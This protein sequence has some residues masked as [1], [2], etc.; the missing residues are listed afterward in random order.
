MQ[1]NPNG[2]G[3]HLLSTAAVVAAMGLVISSLAPWS[4]AIPATAAGLAATSGQPN[5]SHFDRRA[6]IAETAAARSF[7]CPGAGLWFPLASGNVGWLYG[8]SNPAVELHEGAVVETGVDFTP[9]GSGSKPAFAPATG[10]VTMVNGGGHSISI[11]TRP[12]SR[13][14]LDVYLSGLGSIRVAVGDHVVAGRSIIGSVSAGGTIHMS[15]GPTGAASHNDKLLHDTQDPS[16]LF[17][18]NVASDNKAPN[19]AEHSS[20]GLAQWCHVR[21]SCHGTAIFVNRTVQC[22]AS[23]WGGSPPYRF[24]WRVAG[25]AQ[26]ARG[27][28][29]LTKF[30]QPGAHSVQTVETDKTGV[31]TKA[32]TAVAVQQPSVSFSQI[33]TGSGYSCGLRA[34]GPEA[35]T[36]VCWGGQPWDP[37]TNPEDTGTVMDAPPDI[38]TQ[39]ASNVDGVTVC[40]LHADGTIA[41]W[42]YDD[43]GEADP[44]AGSYVSQVSVAGNQ[45][46]GLRPDGTM[47]CSL[48]LGNGTSA[49]GRGPFVQI[50]A[51]DFYACGLDAN[52]HASC[53][54]DGGYGVM[55]TPPPDSFTQISTSEDA[56]CGLTPGG[57]VLCWGLDSLGQMLPPSGPHAGVAAGPDYACALDE[58]R[59]ASCWGSANDILDGPLPPSDQA[60]TQLVLGSQ[61]G[62][63]LSPTQTVTC[64]GGNRYVPVKEVP[65]TLP[66]VIQLSAGT[67]FVCALG[68]DG[69]VSCWGSNYVWGMTDAPA[70]TFV[71]V[72]AGSDF[73]CA[74]AADGSVSCWGDGQFGETDPPA[75]QFTQIAA[76]WDYAC[77]LTASGQAV[78][79]GDTENGGMEP[80]PSATF[81]SLA[82]GTFACGL[83]ASGEM[84]C[85]GSNDGAPHYVLPGTFAQISLGEDLGNPP[86]CGLRTDGTVLC[87]GNPN[88]M[89]PNG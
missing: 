52:G 46:C 17:A 6:L 71:Q 25:K 63:G 1:L 82:A 14:N 58:T 45:A 81:T 29:F 5:L 77:G 8:D 57:R 31:S 70:G 85:W 83:T 11:D 39:I 67:D 36:A 60:F 72:A 21:V 80:A 66:P 38:F 87:A 89:L 84:L 40:G 18:A 7:A 74:L 55:D 12:H 88:A 23:A 51:A 32:T 56:A 75:D 16:H 24:E 41:C 4:P 54:G 19:H 47:L 43:E 64:W 9:A 69:T 13:R 79:W 20:W 34:S 53:F 30:R 76:G 26:T 65:Q 37:S 61:W 49:D 33:A 28:N 73:A 35:G 27:P 10:L 78:C 48:Q 22:H 50:S 59:G 3:H 44:P 62:C 86:V 42:G 68:T 2:R 15:I